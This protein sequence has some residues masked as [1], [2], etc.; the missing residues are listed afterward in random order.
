MAGLL[1]ITAGGPGD[2]RTVTDNQQ[3]HPLGSVMAF[4]DGRRFAYARAGSTAI[5]AAALCQQTLNSA[6]F[7]ELAV[8][9]AV[10]A[11][12]RQVTVTN[13]ATAVTVDQL[14]DGYLN[15]EDDA[16]EGYVYTVKSNAAAAASAALVVDLYE[17]VQVAWT[18]ATTVLVYANPYSVVIVHP[19]PATALLLGFTNGAVTA[20]DYC[21]LQTWGA[22]CALTQGSVV[23]NEGVIDSASLAGAVAPTAS[24]AAGE[25][26]YVGIVMEVAATTEHSLVYAKVG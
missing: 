14:K 5:I 11:N 20:N 7:D 6:N 1:P 17:P 2:Q 9:A 24:T 21:W 8:P 13:G 22:A 4:A 23:T 25:E 18:T 10:A 15:V 19:P 3:N 16:G 26:N 12:A